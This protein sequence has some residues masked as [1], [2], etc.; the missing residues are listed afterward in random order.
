MSE[1]VHWS[2][3]QTT[4]GEL[5]VAANE[6]GVCFVA[7]CGDHGKLRACF[8]NA[9]LVRTEKDFRVIF[10]EVVAAVETPLADNSHIPLDLSGS[11][12]QRK[13][14]EALR[15]IPPGETRSYGEQAAMLG[16]AKASRAV[17]GANAANRIAVL[18]PCHRVVR[19]DG[20]PGGYAHG[21]AIKRELLKREAKGTRQ[22]AAPRG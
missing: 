10:D 21:T 19:A 9:E 1:H 5:L 6:R 12:F 8:P 3:R 18:I 15:A 16:N 13:C 7:F 22:R 14:W 20:S 11:P 4:L 17:G 2:V